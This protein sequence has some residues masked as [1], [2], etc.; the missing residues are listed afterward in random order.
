MRIRTTLGSFW[1]ARIA[2]FVSVLVFA[3][4][5]CGDVPASLDELKDEGAFGFVMRNAQTFIDDEDLRVLCQNDDEYFFVQAIIW[6]DG[7][8]VLGETIDGRPIGDGSSIVL[9]LN[10]D[11]K[12]TARIDR[13]YTLNPWPSLPGLHYTIPMG[14]GSSTSIQKDS[15]GRG[16][17]R[18]LRLDDER[19]VRVDT[20]AIP[21]AEIGVRVGD[22]IRAAVLVSSTA[23]E[24][25]FT[26][27]KQKEGRKVKYARD[28]SFRTFHDVMLRAGQPKSGW[29][30]IPEGRKDR[31][32][33]AKPETKPLLKVGD[34]PPPMEA[35]EWIGS[36]QLPRTW[37]ALRGN[38]VLVDFWATWCAPCVEGIPH[39]NELQAKH[40]DDG[41]VVM[42]FTDQSKRGITEF[43][44]RVKM[45]YAVG[46]GSELGAKFGAREL[47]HVFLIGRDGKLFWE[48]HPGD[49]LFSDRLD[50]ALTMV[51]T[52]SDAEA[53]VAAKP[54]PG[55][56]HYIDFPSLGKTWKGVPA[57]A[58]LYLPKNYDSKKK[59]P[60]LVAFGGGAGTDNPGRAVKLSGGNDFIC[61]GVPYRH[62]DGDLSGGWQTDWDYYVTILDKVE[63][64]VPNIDHQ[65]RACTGFSSGGAAILHQIG[66]SKGRFQNYFHAFVPCG[67]G[68]PMGGLETMKGVP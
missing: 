39:L 43:Q 24:L 26:S 46:C 38:V 12:R 63:D 50:Q 54:T 23:P 31:V 68:W 49:E 19:I 32:T 58:G 33:V 42:G 9:D 16:A 36:D 25:L 60:L 59:F 51:A 66:H 3:A 41:L 47:P 28:M 14:R 57:R 15:K 20:Y 64:L 40:R 6:N 48:G 4:P 65:R 1:L 2:V 10:A 17:I 27:A 52:K 22:T 29:K 30:A 62:E 56:V 61:L 5:L 21:L 35:D 18:Y 13:T 34:I 45:Q 37:D 55:K 67:A 8:D 44:K 53:E 7:D 11:G